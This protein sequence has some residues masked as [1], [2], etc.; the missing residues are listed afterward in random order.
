MSPL[1]RPRRNRWRPHAFDHDERRLYRH[2]VQHV[3]QARAMA[4]REAIGK[5]QWLQP[6]AGIFGDL[7]A[8]HVPRRAAH[9][10]AFPGCPRGELAQ[11]RFELDELKRT[12]SVGALR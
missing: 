12:I 10:F 3:D 1:N 8:F 11:I 7:A 6:F 9:I 4:G 2:Q 5:A